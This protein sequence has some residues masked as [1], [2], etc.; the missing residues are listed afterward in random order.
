MA[1]FPFPLFVYV[2]FYRE[3]KRF[4]APLEM[5]VAERSYSDLL[6]LSIKKAAKPP[7][8]S[9]YLKDLIL[10]S[11]F[12][13]I[14]FLLVAFFELA[15]DV[16][17]VDARVF[18]HHK[19]V[20]EEVTG[21]VDDLFFVLMLVG[22]DDFRGFF[23]DLLVDLVFAFALQVI[24]V[25]LILRMGAA[26]FDLCKKSMKDRKAS[27]SFYIF[28]LC[29]VSEEAGGMIRMA[30][31]AIGN[32]LHDEGVCIAVHE[33]LLYMLEVGRFF[34]FVPELLTASGEE[35]GLSRLDG[36]LQGLLIH[37]SHHEDLAASGVLHNGRHKAF[38]IKGNVWYRYCIH[39]VCL[40]N[41][42][43]GDPGSGF[44][45]YDRLPLFQKGDILT[46]AMP[47]GAFIDETPR[48]QTEP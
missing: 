45:R 44:C 24:G 8:F 47:C 29:K 38:F 17:E 12:L 40:S 1:G 4:L 39:V 33:D 35:P 28:P 25:R 30:G 22:D 23:A 16:V 19:Q 14:A 21:L 15:H 36:F 9:L 18:P 42:A 2:L 11:D 10:M 34:A 46:N 37:I 31:R 7:P 48:I 41:V 13:F 20:I 43:V 32:D 3:R 27:C 26:V 5:T 6:A